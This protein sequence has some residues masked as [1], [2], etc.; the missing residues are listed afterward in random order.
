[1]L[2][3]NPEL[4]NVTLGLTCRPVQRKRLTAY[5]GIFIEARVARGSLNNN[6]TTRPAIEQFTILTTN[7]SI[8]RVN[9]PVKRSTITPGEHLNIF[10]RGIIR[11]AEWTIAITEGTYEVSP[12]VRSLITGLSSHT[13]TVDNFTTTLIDITHTIGLT[14]VLRANLCTRSNSLIQLI[15]VAIGVIGI[16]EVLTSLQSAFPTCLIETT[17]PYQMVL[18][19]LTCAAIIALGIV[20][21][22]RCVEQ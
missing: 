8:E 6:L 13:G 16:K 4:V 19:S 18:L 10:L 11:M 2:T 1:M 12:L 15:P 22:R 20:I 3:V 21:D 5:D 17:M 14:I 9:L 7:V